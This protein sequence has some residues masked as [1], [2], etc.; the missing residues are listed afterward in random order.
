MFIPVPVAYWERGI[1]K[2]CRKTEDILCGERVEVNVVEASDHEAPVAT[3][4]KPSSLKASGHPNGVAE[5]RWFD[6]RH[7]SPQTY[8]VVGEPTVHVDAERLLRDCENGWTDANPLVG[9]KDCTASDLGE[10]AEGKLKSV[11]DMELRARY[12]NARDKAIEDAHERASDVL[13][14]RGEDGS[15]SVWTA[16]E[17]PVYKVDDPRGR[18]DYIFVDVI[19]K[20]SIGPLSPNFSIFRADRFDD[21][22][23]HVRKLQE[24]GA[25]IANMP[26]IHVLV[27]ES[28]TYDDETPAFLA[29]LRSAV[30]WG[31][32]QL[33]EKDIE[34]IVAWATLRDMLREADAAGDTSPE[35]LSTLE[36]ALQ[37]YRD[38]R[39]AR[40][41]HR[42]SD[43]ATTSIDNALERWRLRPLALGHDAVPMIGHGR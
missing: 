22:Q 38:I 25:S 16:C 42:F 7:F 10:V 28:I 4:W 15:L 37:A 27:P 40:R 9:T 6:G 20:G 12:S 41:D 21:M 2:G 23:D 13:L 24:R 5:T 34:E 8:S 3:R 29:A 19:G 33:A 14:V 31:K 36:N 17:E 1:R 35:R 39:E 43:Y 32:S 30:D 11:E 18:G 26:H